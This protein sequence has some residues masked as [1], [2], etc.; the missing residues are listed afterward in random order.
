MERL[1]LHWIMRGW[2]ACVKFN[3][4]II[5]VALLDAVDDLMNSTHLFG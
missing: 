1:E 3:V 2:I 5:A 4:I